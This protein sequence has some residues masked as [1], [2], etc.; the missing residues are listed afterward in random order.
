MYLKL[1][2]NVIRE[3]ANIMKIFYYIIFFY[4][5]NVKILFTL[6]EINLKIY[7]TIN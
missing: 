3:C 5:R 6:N 2:F 7:E 4:L 1:V